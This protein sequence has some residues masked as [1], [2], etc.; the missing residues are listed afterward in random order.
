MKTDY[1]IT[2]CAIAVLLFLGTPSDAPADETTGID[3]V[4]HTAATR[5]RMGDM[6]V[7]IAK[8]TNTGTVPVEGLAV[9]L[10][11]VCLESGNEYPVDLEDWSAKKAFRIARLAPGESSEQ[12]WTLRLIASGPY[13]VAVTVINKANARPVI[14]D[15]LKFQIQPKPLISSSRILPVSFVMPLLLFALILYARFARFF[16]KNIEG[17][18]GEKI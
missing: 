14:S 17:S 8:V 10:S 18:A 9:Y 15:L 6:P 2:L 11:L 13:A 7:F 5:L 16:R 12:E 3:V 4:I 1:M